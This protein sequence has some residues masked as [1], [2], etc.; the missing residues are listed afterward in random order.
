MKHLGNKALVYLLCATLLGGLSDYT[1]A[2][3]ACTAAVAATCLGTF[4]YARKPFFFVCLAYCAATLFVPALSLFLP[5]LFYDA[6]GRTMGSKSSVACVLAAMFLSLPDRPL[7]ASI[8]LFIFSAISYVLQ[9]HCFRLDECTRQ[10]HRYRDDSTESSRSLR[11]KNKSL[12]AGQDYEIHLATL[13]ERNR[14]ARE[15]HDNV[16]HML[17]RAILQTG[18][19]ET[20]NKDES[21]ST[22]LRDLHTTLDSAMTSIRNSVHDL[23][24]EAVNLRAALS[25]IAKTSSVN[26]HLDYDVETD[27]PKEMKYA[28]IAIVREAVNNTQKHS[29]ADRIRVVV[30]E[31]PALYQL[32]IEDNGTCPQEMKKQPALQTSRGIGLAN[33][34]ERIRALNGN[35]RFSWEHGF[36]I[37]ISVMKP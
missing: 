33:M 9:Y 19:L 1:A 13:S 26:V 20:I 21:L 16:G 23:H 4:F 7:P 3:A 8:S 22:P 37:F 11:Q 24:D 6:A 15:I 14:I 18:V 36:R 27:L 31:H 12:I 10:F 28:F 35:I 5:V 29:D 17:T 34:E 2:A 30:K 32:F 25:D